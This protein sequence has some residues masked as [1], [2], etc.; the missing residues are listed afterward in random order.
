VPKILIVED[1][2]QVIKAV[3]KSFSLEQGFTSLAVSDPDRVL[4]EAISYKPD[5][6]LLDIKLP[7][8]D[9]RQLIKAL[10][11]NSAT[12]TIPVIFL[13]GMSSEGDRVLG[14]NLGADDYLVKPFGAME[15]LARIQAVL[16]RTLPPRT[17]GKA[18][19]ARGLCLDEGN[20]TATLNG[21]S[22]KLQP[23]EFEVLFQLASRAGRTLTRSFLIEN[24]SSYGTDVSSRS[25]DT[26]VKNLRRKLGAAG[27]WIETI[28]KLGYRFAPP[29]D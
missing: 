3:E 14:L 11:E 6:I 24:T 7:G 8:G 13:T 25:L 22:L 27:R 4:R 26:H 21:K 5:L 2:P 28:P 12:R 16:R 9:G 10:K 19:S 1:D 18:L 15:L 23:R 17:E 29:N 20:R